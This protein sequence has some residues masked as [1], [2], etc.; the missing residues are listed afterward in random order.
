M[1]DVENPKAMNP[2]PPK[3]NVHAEEGLVGQLQ[4]L[5]GEENVK[6]V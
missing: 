2:L 1:I 4:A 6:V 3:W 5:Y